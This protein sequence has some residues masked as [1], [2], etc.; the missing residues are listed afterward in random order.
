M[1]VAAAADCYGGAQNCRCHVVD[2][3]ALA[4]VSADYRRTRYI[5]ELLPLIQV[6]Y[7]A[8]SFSGPLRNNGQAAGFVLFGLI[9]LRSR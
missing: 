9:W 6:T 7:L 8:F 2:S 4:P 3:I 5:Y 1:P